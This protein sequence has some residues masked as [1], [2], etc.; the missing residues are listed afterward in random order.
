MRNVRTYA[1]IAFGLALLSLPAAHAE[2]KVAQGPLLPIPADDQSVQYGPL[3][4]PLGPPAALQPIPE[5]VEVPDPDGMIV[6][7]PPIAMPEGDIALY[8]RVRYRRERNI[9]PDAVPM[10]V[11]VREPRGGLF[12]SN[13][14]RG[15]VNVEVCVPPCP[16]ADVKI[17]R[18]GNKV[19]YCFGAYSVEITTRL[20][21]IV[22]SYHD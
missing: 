1:V 7:A 21:D 6:D 10:V 3:P 14:C 16:P 2:I 17:K 20:T 19:C 11:S 9:A 12:A 22:V 4:E 15:S 13:C 8:S 5:G 18:N